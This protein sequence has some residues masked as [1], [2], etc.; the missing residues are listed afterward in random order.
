MG[1]SWTAPA[2]RGCPTGRGAQP[3]GGAH[4]GGGSQQGGLHFLEAVL[5]MPVSSFIVQ[6][7]NRRQRIVEKPKADGP[8]HPQCPRGLWHPFGMDRG[9]LEANTA[10]VGQVSVKDTLEDS[11]HSETGSSQRKAEGSGIRSAP[12]LPPFPQGHVPRT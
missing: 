1:S 3:G 10:V 6:P 4:W 2:G 11:S 12:G 7:T 5:L 8:K 9:P